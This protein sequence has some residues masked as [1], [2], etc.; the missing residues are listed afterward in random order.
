MLLSPFFALFAKFLLRDSFCGR[1]KL[2]GRH[3]LVF[4]FVRGQGSS[5]ALPR[6]LLL[7]Q[8][9]MTCEGQNHPRTWLEPIY[10]KGMRRGDATKHFSM[11]EK[12]FLHGKG[13]GNSVSG[14]SGKDLSGHHSLFSVHALFPK[15]F[16]A[17]IHWVFS[18]IRSPNSHN[19][20]YVHYSLISRANE[21]TCLYIHNLRRM[22]LANVP[23]FTCL[24][25]TTNTGANH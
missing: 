19:H 11:S 17:L 24:L 21:I 2:G 10:G 9:A 1:V 8:E 13:G 5:L 7:Q 14:G 20:S 12:R 15:V 18:A 25:V 6:F 22:V 23:P 16:W 4:F 3:S